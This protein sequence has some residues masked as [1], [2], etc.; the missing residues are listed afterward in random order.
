MSDSRNLD[1]ALYKL[2]T[3][4]QA[5]IDVGSHVVG[6]LGR[7]APSSSRELLEEAGRALIPGKTERAP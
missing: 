2:Q 1:A 3:A 5:L 6:A 4:I 7:R